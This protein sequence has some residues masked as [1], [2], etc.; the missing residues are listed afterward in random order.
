MT[1][2]GILAGD[3]EDAMKISRGNWLLIK[4]RKDLKGGD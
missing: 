3:V 2:A 1:S 4:S